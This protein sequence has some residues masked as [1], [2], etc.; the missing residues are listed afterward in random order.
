MYLMFKRIICAVLILTFALSLSVWASP[1]TALTRINAVKMLEKLLSCY[2]GGNAFDDCDD[3]TVK[4][5]RRMG[6]ING[7]GD[8]LFIPE[9]EV[10]T[11]EFFLM[12]KRTLDVACPDL[13]YDNRQIKWHYDQNEVFW[14]YQSHIAFLSA[15]GV[16]NNS[17]YLNPSK[18]ISEGMADYYIGLALHTANYGKRSKNGVLPQKM[19]PFL[20]YHQIGNPHGSI[21]DYVFVSEYNFENQIKYLYENG[22]AFLF[23][24]EISLADNIDK[25]VVITFD[26]GYRS[27]YEK[28]YPILRKYNAKATLFAIS[29][30]IGTPDYCTED[31]LHEMSDNGVFRIYSHT[32]S[33]ADL[34]GLS[35]SEIDAEFS[36]SND[37]IYNI[38]KREVTSVAYPHGLYN[39]TVIGEAMRYYKSAFAVNLGIQMN[40]FAIP[41][42]TID[43]S[44]NI[45]AF[46]LRLK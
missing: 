39:G 44:L 26:D 41:R 28:A 46:K 29:D 14:Y 37:R 31:E 20:M 32:S 36:R 45:E 40:M 21:F 10:S 17:G 11:E 35:A 27:V 33:H 7:T 22:Y 13:F 6:I 5:Y 23:P 1:D 15:V 18:I 4:Y 12:L 2:G 19:P 9:R 25:A 34:P 30:M 43:D 8:N 16:Y 3:P 42:K 24:E 38:T